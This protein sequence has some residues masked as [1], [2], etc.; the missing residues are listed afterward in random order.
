MWLTQQFEPRAIFDKWDQFADKMCSAGI[1]SCYFLRHQ[2]FLHFFRHYLGI[3]SPVKD[4]MFGGYERHTSN[5]EISV[6]LYIGIVK[7]F[8][9]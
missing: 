2:A 8:R 6:S 4:S 1:I 7:I 3:K 9:G 5:L